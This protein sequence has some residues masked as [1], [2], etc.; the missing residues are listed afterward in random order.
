MSY[1]IL[2]PRTSIEVA[3]AESPESLAISNFEFKVMGGPGMI[4]HGPFAPVAGARSHR[5]TRDYTLKSLTPTPHRS[6]PLSLFWCQVPYLKSPLQVCGVFGNLN[7]RFLRQHTPPS[8][9]QTVAKLGDWIPAELGA[10][11]L[12]NWRRWRSE[13]TEDTWTGGT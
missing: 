7:H 1:P 12:G 3:I 8:R 11:W 5:N 9:R 10:G 2:G 13:G 4:R 6:V